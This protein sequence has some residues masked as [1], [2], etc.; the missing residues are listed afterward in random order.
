MEHDEIVTGNPQ[1][2]MQQNQERDARGCSEGHGAP[3]ADV[4]QRADGGA[5]SVRLLVAV[6]VRLGGERLV[7]TDVADDARGLVREPR[8]RKCLADFENL[9]AVL[10]VAQDG[11]AGSI[12]SG[13]VRRGEG[14][15]R[16]GATGVRA[17][18][19]PRRMGLRSVLTSGGM[20]SSKWRVSSALRSSGR[21]GAGY[22]WMFSQSIPRNHG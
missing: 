5:A 20:S 18:I 21:Y 1:T 12:R 3:R 6:G 22:L 10:S 7:R 8:E 17:L 11:V 14:L 2:E 15:H 19:P 4:A 13:A 9:L 16:C